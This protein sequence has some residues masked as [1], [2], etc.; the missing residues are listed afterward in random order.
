[1]PTSRPHR[2]SAD[3]LYTLF[4]EV[5]NPALMALLAGSLTSWTPET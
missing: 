4:E 5:V 3:R 2:L 1:M